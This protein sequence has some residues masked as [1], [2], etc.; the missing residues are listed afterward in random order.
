MPAVPAA[1]AS[2]PAATAAEPAMMAGVAKPR[3]DK[4]PEI[5]PGPDEA[6]AD[7][8]G[9]EGIKGLHGGK[10]VAG[11]QKQDFD[12][13][14]HTVGGMAVGQMVEDAAVAHYPVGQGVELLGA[15]VGD[16]AVGHVGPFYEGHEPMVELG[17]SPV[18]LP[19]VLPVIH[20]VKLFVHM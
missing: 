1:M 3:P 7:G 8:Q 5:R 15:H 9:D 18:D 16:V 14:A 11:G 19:R 13:I 20:G 2:G 10:V 12:H 17:V 6:G 4:G